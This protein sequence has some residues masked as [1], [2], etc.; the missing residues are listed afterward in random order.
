M[1]Q[2]DVHTDYAEGLSWEEAIFLM[3]RKHDGM[4]TN[5]QDRKEVVASSE[6]EDETDDG[7]SP[8]ESSDETDK[9]HSNDVTGEESEDDTEADTGDDSE[10]ESDMDD[11]GDK[12]GSD[13]ER[14]DQGATYQM[15][16]HTCRHSVR[17]VHTSK[18][19]VALIDLNALQFVVHK[20]VV[21]LGMAMSGKRMLP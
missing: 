6:D 11:E 19:A 7:S 16:E 9:E 21:V 12:H 8:E 10:E 1:S 5:Y 20:K 17:L 14:N 18:A 4:H 13:S 2:L 15:D 3:I